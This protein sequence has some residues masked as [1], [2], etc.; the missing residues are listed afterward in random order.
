MTIR[1]QNGRAVL[2]PAGELTIFEAAEFREALLAL[3]G[4][5]GAPELSLTNI[6]RMDSSCVQLVVAGCQE[7][8]LHI[9]DVSPGVQAQFEVIGCRKYLNGVVD[10]SASE[11]S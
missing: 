10:S 11:S 7:M 6:D 3:S 9:T 4:K 5:E 2:Q 1:E 8:A